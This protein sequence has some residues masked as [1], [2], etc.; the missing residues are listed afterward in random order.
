MRTC[1]CMLLILLLVTAGCAYSSETITP[2]G[3]FG[4]SDGK[5]PES[6]R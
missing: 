6:A 2:A 5:A 3:N 1:S 4:L